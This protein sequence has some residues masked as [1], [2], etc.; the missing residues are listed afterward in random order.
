MNLKKTRGGVEVMLR[1]PYFVDLDGQIFPVI[2]L[3]LWRPILLCDSPKRCDHL[4]KAC[5]ACLSEWEVDYFVRV[6][7]SEEV[8]YESPRP[9][10]VD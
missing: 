2:E 10:G 7:R 3:M 6:K 5:L 1:E 9:L 4:T 8:L